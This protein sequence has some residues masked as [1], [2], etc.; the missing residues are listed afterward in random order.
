MIRELS[1]ECSG[2]IHSTRLFREL[3]DGTIAKS[4][5]VGFVASMYLVVVTF[6]MALHKMLA[7]FD[8]VLT[9]PTVFANLLEQA[10]EELRHN[11]LWREMLEAYGVDHLKLYTDFS[12]PQPVLNMIDY[13]MFT[14][15]HPDEHLACQVAMECTI[16]NIVTKTIYPAVLWND[17]LNGSQEFKE[18]SCL[19]WWAEH[20]AQDENGNSTA[21]ARHIRRTLRMV[22]ELLPEGPDRAYL[23]VKETLELFYDCFDWHDDNEFDVQE[24]T[25]KGKMAV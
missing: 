19:A 4:R 8:V 13:Q 6:P 15:K 20:L 9:K 14:A 12:M 23:Y 21:E 17:E 22:D 3:A 1:A 7:G 24:F 11:Q 18:D 10:K 2:R 16:L 5:F 25:L